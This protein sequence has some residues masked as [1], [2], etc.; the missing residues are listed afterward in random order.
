MESIGGWTP[1]PH[2]RTSSIV[3]GRSGLKIRRC[4]FEREIGDHESRVLARP[5]DGV[6]AVFKDYERGCGSPTCLWRVGDP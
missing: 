3:T 5:D 1:L 6:K 2:V 4:E